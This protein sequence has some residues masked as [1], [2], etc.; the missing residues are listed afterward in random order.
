MLEQH[1]HVYIPVWE[2]NQAEVLGSHPVC[3]GMSRCCEWM[4]CTRSSVLLTS[5]CLC[6]LHAYCHC[7]DYHNQHSY[8]QHSTHT[9]HYG[10][11]ENVRPYG[12]RRNQ[13]L[14]IL[15]YVTRSD[16]TL[17]VLI[18]TELR[19]WCIVKWVFTVNLLWLICAGIGPLSAPYTYYYNFLK[20][21][22]SCL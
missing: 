6:L 17:A 5:L 7:C 1:N 11:S 12:K 2:W 18:D 16:I 13:C 22:Y 8:K 20:I 10:S 9:S 3:Q 15:L 21:I 14:Y 4:L 19:S